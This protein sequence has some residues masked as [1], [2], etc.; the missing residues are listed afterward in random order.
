MCLIIV[1]FGHH[2]RQNVRNFAVGLDNDKGDDT[3]LDITIDD[4][5]DNAA[6]GE[7][8]DEQNEDDDCSLSRLGNDKDRAT[9]AD[10]T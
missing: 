3:F 8:T 2:F 6:V 9:R 10:G 7:D 1:A 5:N 4:I